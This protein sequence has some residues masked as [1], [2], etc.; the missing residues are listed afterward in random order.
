MNT[1]LADMKGFICDPYLDDVLCYAEEFEA[2]VLDLKKVLR[3]LKSRGIKLRA[4]KC[5]FLKQEVRYLGRLISGE[6]YRM[7]PEDTAALE[8]FREQPKNVGELR[9]LLGFLGYYRC[10][11]RNFARIVKPLYDLLRDDGGDVKDTKKG[12]AGKTTGQKYDARGLIKWSEEMQEIVEGLIAHLKSGEVIAFPNFDLPF[13]M[14]TDASGYGLGA[15]LYQSQEGKDRV[16]A[17]AS[18]TLTDAETNYN[19]HSGKLEFLALKWAVTERF[20]DYLRYGTEPFTV[21]TDNNPLTYV[22][23][24]AKLNATGLRWVADLAEFYFIIKYRPGK[25]NSDAD[26]LSRRP[27][28]ISELKKKCTESVEPSSVAAVMVNSLSVSRDSGMVA[29]CNAEICELSAP[30]EESLFVG[31]EEMIEAQKTDPVIGPVL[32]YV[33]DSVR[34]SR[35]EFAQLPGGTKVL[36]RSFPKLELV[37]GVLFRQTAKYRQIVLPKKYHEI[38]YQELHVKMAHV[39]AEKV[40]KLAR[41][42]FYW[43][44]MDVDITNYV[45]KK[46]RCMVLKEP[47]DKV[48]APLIPIQATYPGQMI[49]IDFL[50]LDV[51]QGGSKYVLIVVDHFTRFAQF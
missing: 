46:C 3:R 23:T 26:G 17:Y 8:K 6:G 18:R 47:N 28:E 27:L 40:L 51:C 12:K 2:G 15:V 4:D 33:R 1:M 31:K 24:S 16:I 35:K 43:P 25:L 50:Q 37:N 11:V 22:L 39:G 29:L 19:L 10:Y 21:Y 14:T 13:F 48:R 34:P 41:Q 42:R 38:V 44:R 5:A 36:M 49:E 20:A 7:D 9:S 32:S 30:D 45:R